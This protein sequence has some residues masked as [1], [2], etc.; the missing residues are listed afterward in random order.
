MATEFSS[1]SKNSER[2]T[3]CALL[4]A[5]IFAGCDSGLSRASERA[6]RRAERRYAEGDFHEAIAFYEKALDGTAE[7][8][9]IHYRLGLIYD[10]K[11]RKPLSALH[12]FERYVSLDPNGAHIKDVRTFIKQDELRLLT[13]LSRGSFV[14]REE[15]ARLKNENL[16][17]RK[18]LAALRAAAAK[19]SSAKAASRTEMPEQKPIPAGARTY[20]VQPGDTLASISRRFYKSSAR[21]KT[22]QDANYGPMEGTV[23]LK[24]GQ[25]LM[26][27]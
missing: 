8:A 19:T 13:M 23:T 1:R 26:I 6:I 15:A 14:T 17:L 2:A 21:W 12:H 4:A 5:L 18:Q 27:P 3:A 22:I 7:T 10:D 24:P 16:A 20:V 9:E 11:L 25:T